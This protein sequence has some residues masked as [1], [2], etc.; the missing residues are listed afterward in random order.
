MSAAKDTALHWL[1]PME[2]YSAPSQGITLAFKKTTE[3]MQSACEY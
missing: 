2:E 1:L 3:S